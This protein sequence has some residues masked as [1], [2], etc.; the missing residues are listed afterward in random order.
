MSQK[1]NA[2]EDVL[3]DVMGEEQPDGKNL[4]I[5]AYVFYI[6]VLALNSSGVSQTRQSMHVC[7]HSY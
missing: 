5:H 3:R 4:P 7:I 1:A 2:L 6:R